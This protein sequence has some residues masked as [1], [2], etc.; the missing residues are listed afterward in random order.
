M[1]LHR[2]W[3][4]DKQEY[5]IWFTFTKQ[6]IATAGLLG[7]WAQAWA[8]GKKIRYA[9]V[10]QLMLKKEEIADMFRSSGLGGSSF[11][12]QYRAQQQNA[13]FGFDMGRET[14]PPPAPDPEWAKVLGLPK[15]AT[16]DQIKSKYRT[17]AK[18]HHPDAGG[19]PKKF[20]EITK[21]Y[22]EAIR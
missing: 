10:I 13:Y 9:D 16:K 20:A 14:K 7:Q 15:T 17:L 2:K 6:E 3:N 18:V 21:A 4:P 11:E 22:E 5:T 8:G 1:K 19:D 12:Q